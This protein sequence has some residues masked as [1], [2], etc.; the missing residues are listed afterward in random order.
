MSRMRGVHHMAAEG[1]PVA[2]AREVEEGDN[3]VFL[4]NAVKG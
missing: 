1:G 2:P 4:E 3:T